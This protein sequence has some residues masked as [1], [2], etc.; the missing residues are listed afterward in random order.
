MLA[1][2]YQHALDDKNRL[3]MPARIREA[4][5]ERFMATKGLEKCLFVYPHVEWARV[6]ERLRQVSFTRADAR[7]FLRLFFSGAVECE[8]D[9]QGRILLP[10]NLV[11]Y[12]GLER[13]VVI[14]GVASR[15]EIWSKPEWERYRQDAEA[16]YAALAESIV[17]LGL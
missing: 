6:E 7:Q 11:D 4:L 2:E 13:D 8:V 10:T 15:V 1:G 9:K 17:D 14:I 16:S 5:G 12:A 3:T